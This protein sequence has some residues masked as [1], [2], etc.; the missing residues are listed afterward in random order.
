LNVRWQ[1]ETSKAAERGNQG[2]FEHQL[3]TGKKFSQRANEHDQLVL[4]RQETGEPFVAQ[5]ATWA[6][7]SKRS[8]WESAEMLASEAGQSSAKTNAQWELQEPRRAAAPAAGEPIP[9]RALAPN[10]RTG[11][12]PPEEE[13]ESQES[14]G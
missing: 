7:F 11:C 10:L 8:T 9:T 2:K 3:S 13:E 12:W 14:E 1:R 6:W 4:S 5:L